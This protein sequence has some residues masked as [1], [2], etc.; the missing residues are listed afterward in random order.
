MHEFSFELLQTMV[1][2]VFDPETISVTVGKINDAAL[3]YKVVIRDEVTK[4][5][6][7]FHVNLDHT[8]AEVEG[9]IKDAGAKLNLW[10]GPDKI[11][12]EVQP[13]AEGA[14]NVD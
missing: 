8:I 1:R 12:D 3:R 5:S 14:H 11:G 13:P 2:K 4:L 9:F 7:T 10:E 6:H